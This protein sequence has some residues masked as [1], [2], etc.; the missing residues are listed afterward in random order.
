MFNGTSH[1]DDWETVSKYLRNTADIICVAEDSKMVV[2]YCCGRHS[3]NLSFK[4]PI[5]DVTELFVE[6]AH[7]K[8]GLGKRLLSHMEI[9]LLKHGVNRIRILVEGVNESA[10][11]FYAASK[12]TEFDMVMCCKVLNFE[13]GNTTKGER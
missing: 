5:A 11:K 2:G 1:P 6:E 13:A 9:E 12:Y 8:K 10:R 7:R 3:R 4:E